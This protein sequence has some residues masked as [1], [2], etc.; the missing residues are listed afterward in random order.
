M[1]DT[2]QR[3]SLH[4]DAAKTWLKLEAD[5]GDAREE[6]RR[7]LAMHGKNGDDGGG[8][9]DDGTEMTER[10]SVVW[11]WV[12]VLCALIPLTG[13]WQDVVDWAGKARI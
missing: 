7:K 6:G 9:F 4:D 11:S 8:E 2:E 3:Q 13:G 1:R 12:L 5:C 10:R